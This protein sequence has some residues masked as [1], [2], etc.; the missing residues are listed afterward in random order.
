MG[1]GANYTGVD[2]AVD[3]L[4]PA[5]TSSLAAVDNVQALQMQAEIDTGWN[6]S[7]APHGGFGM[8]I[9]SFPDMQQVAI[10]PFQ[11]TSGRYPGVGEIVLEYGDQQLQSIAIGDTVTVNTSPDATTTLKVVGFA[12]TQGLASP[13]STRTGRGYVSMDGFQQAFGATVSSQIGPQLSYAVAF[14]VKN[15][16]LESS[17][18]TAVAA[19]LKANGVTVKGISYPTPFIPALLSPL[20]ALFTLFGFVAMLAV[21]LSSMLILNTIIALVAEQTQIM[22][23]MKTLGGTRGTILCGY[24]VSVWFYSILGTLPWS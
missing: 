17:T 5:L 8:D 15:T 23:T 2:V 12:R 13:V 4:V 7:S 22:G 6:V 14:K 18:A 11:L 24:L 9:L 10:T 3:K 16:Q 1:S 21:L 19:V 20:N